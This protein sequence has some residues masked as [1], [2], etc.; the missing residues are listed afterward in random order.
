MEGRI[1]TGHLR[2][3]RQLGHRG[4]D[5]GQVRRIVQ[6]SQIGVLFDRGDDLIVNRNRAAKLLAAVHHAVT[7]GRDVAHVVD[8]ADVPLAQRLQDQLHALPRGRRHAVPIRCCC[9][10]AWWFREDACSPIRSSIPRANNSRSGMRYNWYLMDELPQLTTRMIMVDLGLGAGKDVVRSCSM[11]SW[12]LACLSD[13]GQ[14]DRGGR[15]D[16]I[17]RGTSRQ[18]ANRTGKSLQEGADGLGAGQILSQLVGDVAGVQV[19]KD[20]H[21][22]LSCHRLVHLWR[23]RSGIRFG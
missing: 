11:R 20:Q 23:G 19:G 21:V 12:R 7:H 5:A 14:H 9:S 17:H 10:P 4:P 8:S 3:I 22:G 13:H 2:G 16:V 1:E 15:D 6:R 18:V